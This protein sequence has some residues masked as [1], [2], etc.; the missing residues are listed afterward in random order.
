MWLCKSTPSTHGC[1]VSCVLPG[2][3]MAPDGALAAPTLAVSCLCCPSTAA[4]LNATTSWS[5]LPL[6]LLV[7]AP[8]IS[9]S[10]DRPGRPS[11]AAATTKLG[12]R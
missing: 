8:S 9:P 3:R 12:C 7:L 11:D 1:S 5:M 10:G 4:L 2:S 6:A